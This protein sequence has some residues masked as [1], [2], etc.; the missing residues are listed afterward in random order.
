MGRQVGGGGLH[1]VKRQVPP[2]LKTLAL[3]PWLLVAAQP[4]QLNDFILHKTF[5]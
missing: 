5:Q 4:F 3:G 1:R 2:D